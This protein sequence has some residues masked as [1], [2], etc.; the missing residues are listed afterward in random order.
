[1]VTA[2]VITLGATAIL[3]YR[4]SY[5]TW[6]L[7]L[8]QVQASLCFRA[9]SVECV[10]RC[11]CMHTYIH[12]YERTY[13]AH[14]YTGCT[15]SYK[16]IHMYVYNMLRVIWSKLKTI[17]HSM[18]SYWNS[19]QAILMCGLAAGH[20]K[21]YRSATPGMFIFQF[22]KY[23]NIETQN[24]L[25]FSKSDQYFPAWQISYTYHTFTYTYLCGVCSKFWTT[26]N[27][28]MWKMRA[29]FD[30]TCLRGDDA[31]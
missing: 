30:C 26:S 15:Y 3:T 14:M 5:V 29:P 6:Y 27:N 18:T 31:M 28:E 10:W 9:E 1:M 22:F 12:I 7:F 2:T 24:V 17:L 21:L 20:H 11:T 16:H 25:H 19:T 4:S 23:E 13:K 8:I